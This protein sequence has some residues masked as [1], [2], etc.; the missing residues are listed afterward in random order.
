M[1]LWIPMVIDMSAFLGFQHFNDSRDPEIISI[2]FEY[3]EVSE[4]A[5]KPL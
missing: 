5:M 4:T 3:Q 1:I 2:I